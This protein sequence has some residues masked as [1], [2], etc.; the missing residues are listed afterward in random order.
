MSSPI[1]PSLEPANRIVQ[2]VA[3]P[4]AQTILDW[5]SYHEL[6][7]SHCLDTLK[8]PLPELTF[9]RWHNRVPALSLETLTSERAWA[10]CADA[11]RT[12]LPGLTKIV[13]DVEQKAPRHLSPNREKFPLAF[14]RDM[15]PG[16]LPFISLH[17]HGKGED[18]FAMAHEFGHAVQIHATHVNAGMLPAPA[19]KECAAFLG[20]L[21]LINYLYHPENHLFFE[22]S[23][24]WCETAEGYFLRDTNALAR[25]LQDL[26]LPTDYAYSWNYAIAIRWA[27]TLWKR[28][29][30]EVLEDIFC[31]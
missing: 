10:L 26:P 31:Q 28:G 15:G 3:S 1:Q 30:K 19:W 9:F 2:Q 5:L 29:D 7:A 6:D 25:A 27:L 18:L 20:E 4:P 8:T 21:I 14:T 11:F 12:A 23:E 24:I 17:Y 16:K 22:L 13:T